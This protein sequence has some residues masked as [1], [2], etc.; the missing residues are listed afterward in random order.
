MKEKDIPDS[1]RKQVVFT[2]KHFPDLV[3][4]PITFRF[5]ENLTRSF[6]Q[7]QPDLKSI[8]STVK[9]RSYTIYISKNFNIE[10]SPFSIED[11]PENVLIGWIAHELGHIIDYKDRSTL[12]LFWFGFKYVTMGKHLREAERQADLFA[13]KNGM[14]DYI[15]QTKNFILNNSSLSERYKERIKRLYLSP[16]DIMQLLEKIEN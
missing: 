15:V 16:E 4:T 1:I 5:K 7:A 2:L 8:F 9:N 13:I 3:N 6:M 10:G 14:G 11:L 12:D